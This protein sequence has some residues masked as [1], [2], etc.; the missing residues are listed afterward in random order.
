MSYKSVAAGIYIDSRTGSFVERPWILGKRTW[1]KLKSRTLK[2]AQRE[3]AA[4]RTDQTRAS[5]GA[6]KDP[7]APP[8]KTVGE[9]CTEY[10]AAGCPDRQHAPKSGKAL[11]AE[12]YRLAKLLPFWSKRLVESVKA[13]DCALYFAWRKKRIRRKVSGG[14][15]VDLELGSLNNALH[16]AASVGKIHANPLAIGRPKFRSGKTIRHCRDFMPVDGNELH[17][18]AG[19][20]FARRRSEALGWQLLIESMTGLRSGEALQLRRD[21]KHSGEPGYIEGETLWIA[22]SKNGTKPFCQIHPALAECI[23]ALK[24]WWLW[25]HPK[26][27]W[28]FPST[29]RGKKDLPATTTALTRALKGISKSPRTSHGLRAFYVTCRRAQGISDGQI[30]DELGQRSGAS[31]IVQVYGS[32]PESWRGGKALDWTPTKGRPAW[33]RLKLPENVIAMPEAVARQ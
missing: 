5:Y 6:A 9:V 18:L 2:D 11:E 30:S 10:Q 1:R 3:L 28:W 16:W 22:R 17:Q 8:S 12:T 31:L 20:L 7:Y 23:E 14:R 4:R 19:K 33:E 15:T 24:R 25:R 26:S 32:I 13:V 27:R 29:R 21:A